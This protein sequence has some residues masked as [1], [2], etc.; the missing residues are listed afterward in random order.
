MLYLL[1]KTVSKIMLSHL[2]TTADHAL[3]SQHTLLKIINHSLIA[4]NGPKKDTLFSLILQAD[5]LFSLNLVN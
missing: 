5:Y 3:Y 4:S 1:N 2:S